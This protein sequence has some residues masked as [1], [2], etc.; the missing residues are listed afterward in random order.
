M[1]PF[2]GKAPALAPH[3]STPHWSYQHHSQDDPKLLPGFQRERKQQDRPPAGVKGNKL[4]SNPKFPLD[5]KVKLPFTSFLRSTSYCT[6]NDIKKLEESSFL[7]VPSFLFQVD[8]GGEPETPV[9][10]RLGTAK[11]NHPIFYD[12]NGRKH[13]KF[14]SCLN[15]FYNDLLPGLAETDSFLQESSSNFCW[16]I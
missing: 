2:R 15:I 13:C 12:R 10:Q 8:R 9:L 5:S 7:L 14:G 3:S 11:L 1:A 16:C 6:P 4:H